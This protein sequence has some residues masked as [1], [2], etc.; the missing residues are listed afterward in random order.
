V[1]ERIRIPTVRVVDE[2]GSQIGIMSSTEAVRL[3]RE[4]GLDLVEVSP[5]AKPPVCR[6]MD[7]G[8][9]KYE[10]SQRAKKA[11]KSQHRI[12]VKEVKFRP[13]ISGHDFDFKVNHA[14]E[15]LEAGNK[16]KFTVMFRGREVAHAD[17]GREILIRASE[18]LADIGTVESTPRL[19]GRTMGMHMV[20]RK[21]RPKPAPKAKDAAAPGKGDAKR[22]GAPKPAPVAEA[23]TEAPE[24]AAPQEQPEGMES[25]TAAGHTGT[26]DTAESDGPTEGAEPAERTKPE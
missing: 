5:M 16:V 22:G 3:A 21:D 8:K 26:L 7:Y 23:E 17:L 20:P 14:R 1:N 24:S 15:F 19:E 13:K 18:L 12:Q 6:V 4:R 11:K 2:D 9:Y 25:D 10:L